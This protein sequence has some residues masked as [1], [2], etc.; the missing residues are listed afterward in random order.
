M[1]PLHYN[2]WLEY[3]GKEDN[4]DTRIEWLEYKQ[5]MEDSEGEYLYEQWKERNS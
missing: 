5:E 1:R 3:Y 4:D 2:R